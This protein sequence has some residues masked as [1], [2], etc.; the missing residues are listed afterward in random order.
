M[1]KQRPTSSVA[2]RAAKGSRSFRAEDR[3]LD[4]SALIP[5]KL[6]RKI[7]PLVR[8]GFEA[9]LGFNDLWRMHAALAGSESKPGPLAARILDYLGVQWT[10]PEEDRTRLGAVRGP[11]VVVANHPLGG[12]DFFA[13]AHLLDSV[14]PGAWKFLSNQILAALPVFRDHLIPLDALG[15]SPAAHALNL[16][17][18]TEALRFLRVGDAIGLFPAARVAHRQRSLGGALADRAWSDHAVRLAVKTGAAVAC[19]HISGR[20]SPLFLRLPPRWPRLRALLLCR[21][22]T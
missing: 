18:L 5:G 7:F 17:G 8:P 6:G 9:L 2:N 13:L 19:L 10:F 16:R 20:N 22:L 15:W 1:F 4:T 3:F 14:R 21:E 12:I 11:L